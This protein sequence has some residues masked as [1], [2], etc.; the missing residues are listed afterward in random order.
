MTGYANQTFPDTDASRR[1]AHLPSY[2]FHKNVFR[3][4]KFDNATRKQSAQWLIDNGVQFDN[5][6][7]IDP[8]E[9]PS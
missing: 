7:F 9:L 1:R 3:S 5:G 2:E 8:E 6:K 4:P